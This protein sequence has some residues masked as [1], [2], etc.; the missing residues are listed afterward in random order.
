VRVEGGPMNTYFRVRIG[1]P[2]HWVQ[3]PEV[4]YDGRS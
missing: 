2:R 1:P 3:A 4:W